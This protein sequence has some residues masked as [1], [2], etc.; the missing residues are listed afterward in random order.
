MRNG[1]AMIVDVDE[2]DLEKEEDVQ[3]ELAP[4]VSR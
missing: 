3:E 1:A 2:K 4:K